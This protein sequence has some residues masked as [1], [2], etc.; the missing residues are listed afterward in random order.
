MPTTYTHYRFG[1]DC[2]RALPEELRAA[3]EA[4]RGLFN[5]G[6]HGPDIFFYYHAVAPN[7]VT[8]YGSALHRRTAKQIFTR[9]LG[10]W[11]GY[12]DRDSMLAYLLGFLCHFALDSVCHGYVN[13]EGPVLGASHNRLE[14][15]YDAH[16]MLRDG[17]T[18]TQVM[19][20]KSLEPTESN[21]EVISRFFD[22][23]ERKVLAALRGQEY[24]MRLLCSPGGTKKHVARAVLRA[25]HLPGNLD[26]LFIDDEVPPELESAMADLDR[27]YAEAL[28]E[29]PGMAKELIGFLDGKGELSERFD[30]DF[31]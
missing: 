16:L 4:H 7:S 17:L 1:Q 15:V 3:V 8:A 28:A 26:D 22:V 13:S 6:V 14:A 27:L 19:R 9:A 24:V 31:E 20:G 5:T 29:Y 23:P 12:H 18:P 30:R 11:H 2:L 25:L 21:A 10:P